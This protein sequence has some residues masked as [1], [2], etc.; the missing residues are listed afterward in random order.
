[1]G[2][3]RQNFIILE[4]FDLI[5]LALVKELG[6]VP[7]VIVL[8]SLNSFSFLVKDLHLQFEISP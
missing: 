4:G 2:D 7:K 1:M 5:L 6:E 3:L 8:H